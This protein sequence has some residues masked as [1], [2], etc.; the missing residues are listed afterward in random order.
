[1]EA[2][3]PFL[4]LLGIAFV[5]WL[6]IIRPQSRRNRELVSMQQS[7]AVGDEV[8][9]TSGIQGTVRG[10][11]EDTFELEVAPGVVLRVARGAVGRIVA[12]DDARDEPAGPEEL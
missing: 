11:A 1:M 2:I 3:A 6:L 7:I 12:R 4:P 8:M 9:L 5:F 10:L